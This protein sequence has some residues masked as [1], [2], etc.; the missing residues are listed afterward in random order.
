MIPIIPTAAEVT[1]QVLYRVFD[2]PINIDWIEVVTTSTRAF[3]AWDGAQSVVNSYIL[4]LASS[5]S[6]DLAATNTV[7]AFVSG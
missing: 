7:K 3:Y 6:T 1:A 5:G 2:F 4:K